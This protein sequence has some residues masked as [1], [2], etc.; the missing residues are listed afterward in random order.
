MIFTTL[1][2]TARWIRK[3]CEKI[4]DFFKI[5]FEKNLQKGEDDDSIKSKIE[6]ADKK[7]AAPAPAPA[8]ATPA[9][10]TTAAPIASHQQHQRQQQ[11]QHQ[12]HQKYL[13]QAAAGGY[14][15]SE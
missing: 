5:I 2:A 6:E 10:A 4:S 11:Q 14:A 8:P 1:R 7:T 13:A 9:T 15:V 12:Q 3:F